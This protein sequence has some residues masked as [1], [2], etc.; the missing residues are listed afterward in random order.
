MVVKKGL[1]GLAALLLALAA[2]GR[3]VLPRAYAQDQGVA[4]VTSPLEGAL[5]SGLVPIT[6]SATHPQFTRYELAFGYSP[7]PTDTWFS[8]Q[9]PATSQVINEVLGLWDTTKITDGQY[10]LRLR[11]FYGEGAYLETF[12][13]NVQVQNSTP[14]AP[15]DLPA[16]AGPTPTETPAPTATTPLIELPPTATTAPAAGGG[17]GPNDDGGALINVPAGRINVEMIGAAFLDGVRLTAIAFLIL[18]AYAGLR[19]LLRWRR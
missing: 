14:A 19:A 8:L 15:T 16:T 11:V 9:A 7:N 13:A 18:G 12:V 6:G 3:G 5:L 2:L 4:I 17:A 10:V 1:I